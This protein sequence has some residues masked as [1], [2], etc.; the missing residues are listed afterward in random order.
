MQV[1]HDYIDEV[2]SYQQHW[3]R[4][5][6]PCRS[7]KPY[8]GYVKRAMNR[9]P[10]SNDLWWADHQRN[11]GGTYTKIKEPEGYAQKKL[12]PK[13]SDSGKILREVNSIFSNI[14][15]GKREIVILVIFMV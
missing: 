5:D 7:S 14:I 12:K 2:A 15:L 1:Y 8:F 11:C 4:C 6:G 10:S 9:A 3:W 13:K